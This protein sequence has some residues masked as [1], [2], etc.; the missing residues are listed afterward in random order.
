M[1]NTDIQEKLDLMARSAVEK[2][3][4]AVEYVRGH[5]MDEMMN[6]VR[7][8]IRRAPGQSIAAAA[9]AGFIVG[10]LVRRDRRGSYDGFQR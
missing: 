8:L 3:D 10:R 4:S 2:F 1:P 7:R 5:E 6:D 9:V